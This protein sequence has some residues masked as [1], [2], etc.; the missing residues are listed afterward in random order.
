MFRAY[1]VQR[2]CWLYNIL[3]NPYGYI[4]Q[5]KKFFLKKLNEK[6]IS[7]YRD[8]GCKDIDGSLIFEGDIFKDSEGKCGIVFYADEIAAFLFFV[9]EENSAYA[10]G[11]DLYE[12]GHIIGN[13]LDNYDLVKKYL[14][15]EDDKNSNKGDESDKEEKGEENIS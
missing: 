5:K 12:K 10:F 15:S 7:V 6:K 9:Y 3:I 2:K 8:T 11:K 4:Y 13:V 14:E 1:D